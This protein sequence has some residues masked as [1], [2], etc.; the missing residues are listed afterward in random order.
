MPALML[1]P[2]ALLV[3]IGH[4]LARGHVCPALIPLPLAGVLIYRFVREPPGRGFNRISRTNRANPNAVRP[5]ALCSVWCC[6]GMPSLPYC[7]STGD[8]T[9]LAQA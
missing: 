6:D 3:P 7:V 8:V 4:A 9:S 2:F 1:L 5:I